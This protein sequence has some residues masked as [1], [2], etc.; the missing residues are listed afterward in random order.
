MAALYAFTTLICFYAFGDIVSTKTKGLI[1]G[2]FAICVIMLIGFWLG[3]P[4]DITNLA[5]ISSIGGVVVAPLVAGIGTTMDLD[6]RKR[7]WKTV[8]VSFAGVATGVLIII[9]V[10]QTLIGWNEAVASA[11]IFAGASVAL[12]IVNQTMTDLGLVD[13]IGVLVITVFATQKFIGVPLCSFSLQKEAYAFLKD[14]GKVAHYAAVGSGNKETKKSKRPL[15]IFCAIDKPAINLA[16]LA[17]VGALSYF[18]G[19][20]TGGKV[21]YL[22]IS[23]IMGVVFTELGFLQKASL[24]KTDSNFM[25]T[26]LTIMT[27]FGSLA[28]VTP[29][30]L[31][32]SIVPVFIV[33]VLGSIGVIISGFICG[34]IFKMSHWLCIALGI[35]CTFGFPTTVLISEEISEIGETEEQ[36]RALRN[37]LTPQ[38]TLAGFVTV[39]IGSVILAGMVVPLMH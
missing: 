39:T 2:V 30:S 18:L 21:H 11:P 34:K 32:A 35:S 25:L 36:K 6:E 16:K 12:M 5:G 9:L 38:M 15:A 26:F 23:L 28:K 27:V 1:S 37:Y 33:L 19:N 20:L 14:E 10:G 7:Q 17:L 29:Q 13:T 3:L 24:G 31:A 4:Q 22:V 8:I